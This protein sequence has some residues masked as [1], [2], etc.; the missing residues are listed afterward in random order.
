MAEPWIRLHAQLSK[1]PVALRLADALCKGDVHRAVGL[2]AIFWGNVSLHAVD[3]RVADR[4][5]AEI[6]GWAEWKGKRGAF[7][8]WLRQ[9]HLDAEGRVREWDEYAGA[10]EIRRA[11]ERQRL[12]EKR[13]V[14]RNAMRDVGQPPPDVAQPPADTGAES[15]ARARS[16]P[17]RNADADADA[18]GTKNETNQPTASAAARGRDMLL[19][20]IGRISSTRRDGAAEKLAQFARGEGLPAK[21][22]GQIP[23]ADEID[24]A[25][26]DILATCD[27]GT[28][29]AI[30]LGAFVA[31]AMQ[32]DPGTPHRLRGDT[33]RSMAD[34]TYDNALAGAL[35]VQQLAK[36]KA[37]S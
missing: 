2:L 17:T 27:L 1:K 35:A 37:T 31:R 32:P 29:S 7:A 8:A 34:E 15:R 16:A 5:D 6:E 22:A 9:H 21:V 33:R 20:R 28:L 11:K 10:L 13:T 36:E 26:L 14:L 24:S 3:G 4:S 18:D 25:C 19:D 12:A 23:T 30:K